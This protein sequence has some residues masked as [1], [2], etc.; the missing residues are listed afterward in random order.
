MPVA[1]LVESL[2]TADLLAHMRD[3]A[4]IQESLTRLAA[5]GTVVDGAPPF[6]PASASGQ[7]LTPRAL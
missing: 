3:E 5:G 1:L 4:Y 7:M 6:P 2:M